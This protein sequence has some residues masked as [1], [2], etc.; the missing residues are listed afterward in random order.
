MPSLEAY[1]MAGEERYSLREAHRKFAAD[2]FNLV[3]TLMEAGDRSEEDDDKMVHAAHASRFHWGEVGTAVNLAR[4]EWQVSRVYSVLRRP[5][6]ALHHAQR[7]LEIC[8][9]HDL[10]AFD[11]AYAHEALARA[12]AI[13]GEVADR[14]RHLELARSAAARIE[15]REDR[16]LLLADL[17]TV[18]AETR[19]A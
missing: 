2:L 17:E 13:A 4:G 12:Y 8:E 7:C 14:D 5:Q 1:E 11:L 16:D 10:G 18:P 3:W 9:R 19:S 15:E 6:P